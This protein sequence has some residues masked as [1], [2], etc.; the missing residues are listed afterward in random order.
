MAENIEFIKVLD[1]LVNLHSPLLDALAKG[2]KECR[3][4]PIVGPQLQLDGFLD[5]MLQSRISRRLIAEQHMYLQNSRDG[6]IG[7]VQIE[8]P[9]W[10]KCFNA[11]EAARAVCLETYGV[12]PIVTID[13]TSKDFKIPYIPAHLHYMLYEIFKNSFRATVEH[14]LRKEQKTMIPNINVMICGSPQGVTIKISDQ[15][16]GITEDKLSKVFEYGYTSVSDMLQANQCN[17]TNALGIMLQQKGDSSQVMAGLGFGLPMSRL[18]ARFF[19]GDL[20]LMSIPGYG[21]DVYLTLKSLDHLGLET[22]KVS[23]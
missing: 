19:G 15:G 16:G 13:E 12:A 9:L 4:K 10:Q 18:Y 23:M 11:A 6:F 5:S 8:L 3:M 21:T 1:Q 2:L 14:Y 20:K 22:V 7:T 17:E